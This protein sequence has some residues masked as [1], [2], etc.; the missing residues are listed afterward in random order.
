M[1]ARKK[2]WPRDLFLSPH[3]S[4]VTLYGAVMVMR[5]NPL[6]VFC[7]NPTGRRRDQATD[8]MAALK[9]DHLALDIAEDGLSRERV[10]EQLELLKTKYHPATVYAPAVEGGDPDHDLVGTLAR[11]MFCNVYFYTT[12][13]AAGERS[14]GDTQVIPT[15]DEHALKHKALSCY[16]AADLPPRHADALAGVPETWYVYR[17]PTA[18]PA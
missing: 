3:H 15:A 17:P 1:A 18:R 16:T 2:P 12:F 7:T 9:A 8:A 6:V 11:E 5:F 10:R 13:N 4:D 14:A